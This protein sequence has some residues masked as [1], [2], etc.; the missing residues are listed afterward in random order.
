MSVKVLIISHLD[1]GH[2]LLNAAKSAY[3]DELPIAISTVEVQPDTDP[4]HLAAE[5]RRVTKS[6]DDGD[7]VLVLADLFGSTPC[8]IARSLDNHNI[9]IITGFNLPMLMR[10]LN[11]AHLPLKELADKAVEGGKNGI[12]IC[13]C[14]EK[15]P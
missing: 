14:E 12:L 15:E 11:Y 4:V 1:I 13:Q 10:V 9:T 2:A 6:L 3:S 5:L 8:N 7:G